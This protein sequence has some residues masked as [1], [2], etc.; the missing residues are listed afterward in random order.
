MALLIS[1][2]GWY[3]FWIKSFVFHDYDT[4]FDEQKATLL[5]L[6]NSTGDPN[7]SQHVLISKIQSQIQSMFSSDIYMKSTLKDLY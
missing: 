6:P 5:I 2:F 4:L 1:C 3:T 7:M